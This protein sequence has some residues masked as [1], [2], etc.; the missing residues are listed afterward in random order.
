MVCIWTPDKDL[1]Q[2]VQERRVVQVDRRG[3]KV[4][5][6]DGVRE[7]F[8][9][10]PV[11]IPDFLA[12]VGDSADGY[13]GIPGIGAVGA[14][15]LLKQHG[16]IERFPPNVLKDAHDLA[17]LFKDLATLRIDAPLF[18]DLEALRWQGPTEAFAA[19]ME[20]F[21]QPQ[22]LERASRVRPGQPSNGRLSWVRQSAGSE[23]DSAP[24]S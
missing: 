6:A 11:Q 9:V 24:D 8:G 14:A 4:R 3:N 2:C 22:V 21:K 19:L 5:D 15:R 17:L 10:D 18:D 20:R 23:L 13:P 7:K 16:S 12:L 1:A